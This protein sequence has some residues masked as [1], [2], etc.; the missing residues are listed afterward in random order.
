M[1]KIILASLLCAASISY[2][3]NK[4]GKEGGG[5]TGKEGGGGQ[6]V[7]I[8]STPYLLDMVTKAVCDPKSGEQVIAEHPDFENRIIKALRKVDWYFANDLLAEA[9]SLSYCFTGPLYKERPVDW[10][11]PVRPPKQKGVKQAGYRLDGVIYIDDTIF[12]DKNTPEFTRTDLILHETMHSYFPMDLFNRQFFLRSMDAKIGEVISGKIRTT[13][14]FHY[15]MSSFGVDFPL[16]VEHLEPY[17]S[18]I[19]F[20]LSTPSAQ[21]KTLADISEIDSILDLPVSIVGQLTWQ[22]QSFLASNPPRFQLEQALVSLMTDASTNE[23]AEI[24][25]DP[26]FVR[27][28]PLTLALSNMYSLS[29]EKQK[30]ILSG[31]L[32]N[33]IYDDLFASIENATLSKQTDGRTV[34]DAKASQALGSYQGA[35]PVLGLPMPLGLPP[36]FRAL[37]NL[38]VTYAKNQNWDYVISFAGAGSPFDKVM[39]LQKIS[40]E[41][42]KAQFTYLL[43]TK[44]ANDRV[45]LISQTLIQE[46]SEYLENALNHDDFVKLSNI[47]FAKEQG[48]VETK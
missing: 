2:G 25:R 20:L 7:D 17:H 22:N 4:T 32:R 16:T 10:G 29:P 24:L 28:H 8:D 47:I 26:R 14:E 12:S 3:A 11:S 18:V 15:D 33:Q 9:K 39:S 41:V 43:E 31:N 19:D 36:D 5:K 1:K 46:M 48:H 38:L 13:K 35:T 42:S 23:F 34:L 21:E 40:D 45:A 44:K 37:A 27:L 30:M 6:I